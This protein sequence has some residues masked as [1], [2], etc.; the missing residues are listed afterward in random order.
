MGTDYN[1]GMKT[2]LMLAAEVR[3]GKTLEEAIPEAYTECGSLEAAATKLGINPST[4]NNWRLRLRIT[5]KKT[6]NVN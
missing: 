2:P 5:V 3:L 4:L 6:L 1:N